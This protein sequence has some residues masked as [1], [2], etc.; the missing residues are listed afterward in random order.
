MS[1]HLKDRLIQE[2]S[3]LKELD[4]PN[5][6]KYVDHFIK[7]KKVYV[8]MEYCEGGDLAHAIKRCIKKSLLLP[9][10]FI[11][12]VL[13]QLTSALEHCHRRPDGSVILH[14]DIKP[15]NVFVDSDLNVK[16]GDFG[17]ADILSS[18]N[19]YLKIQS[20]TPL[21]MCPEKLN[22]T[23]YHEKSDIWALGCLL[24]ELCAL[25]PLFAGKGGKRLIKRVN[26]GKVKRI[27]SQY[28]D[29]L[30]S[31]IGDML[32][33]LD[34]LRP[35]TE[36]IL[37]SSLLTQQKKRAGDSAHHL[38]APTT[39]ADVS[40]REP[41]D[42]PKKAQKRRLDVEQ[43]QPRKKKRKR[44]CDMDCCMGSDPNHKE[45]ALDSAVAHQ[46]Y[47]HPQP[48]ISQPSNE[49]VPSTESM[50]IKAQLRWV[51]HVMCM[52]DQWRPKMVLL[53]IYANYVS[54]S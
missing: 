39:A 2:I 14:Q 44:S 37:H 36:E 48:T 26:R 28:S 51:G 32:Q 31:L 43:H 12:Q 52:D 49:S 15:A 24:Y 42:T 8:V 22:K 50:I 47:Q 40:P 13:R 20:G 25:K 29:E 38:P 46:P 19:E 4:H 5:I 1:K 34:F 21:Y 54:E 18:R 53:L 7:K 45:E 11:R 6:V 27:P 10:K 16:L 17:L 9:E 23:F 41:Q 30:N 33:V 3:L 35:S